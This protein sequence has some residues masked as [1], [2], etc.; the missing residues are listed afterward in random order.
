[1]VN[2]YFNWCF[3][4]KKV[5]KETVLRIQKIL[6]KKIELILL[7]IM[8]MKTTSKITLLVT[9]LVFGATS[10]FAQNNEQIS[11][12]VVF[13]FGV[14][15]VQFI[16]WSPNS[17]YQM[18]LTG[19]NEYSFNL[20]HTGANQ[21]LLFNIRYDIPEYNMNGVY[22]VGRTGLQNISSHPAGIIYGKIYVNNRLLN[23][24]FV[25]GNTINDGLNISLLVEDDNL[26]YP[27]IDDANF[28]VY[29]DD[30]IPPEVASRYAYH[31]NLPAPTYNHVS[32]WMQIITDNNII[33]PS[34]IEVDYF[35]LY[36][37]SGDDLVLLYEDQYE[38]Y[39]PVADGGL[40]LRYPFFPAGFDDHDPMPGSATDGV[41]T[42]YPSDNIRKVWHFWNTEQTFIPNIHDYDSYRIECKIRITG[43]ALAQG[44]IDFIN[45][46][47]NSH[48]ELGTSDWYF[49]NGGEWQ[50]VVFDSHESSTS[51]I[52]NQSDFFYTIFP[53]PI[54][55]SFILNL[56]GNI[57]TDYVTV[58]IFEISGKLLKERVVEPN[59]QHVFCLKKYDAGNYLIKLVQ[60]N[61]T[62][63]EILIKR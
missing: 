48:Y 13:P 45:Q 4:M 20:Q 44:G 60:R 35:K 31:R 24:S 40:Y 56:S 28:S 17:P 51:A 46:S 33:N 2:K 42:F 38:T 47:I 41:L 25:T 8:Y 52:N 22:L 16:D 37:R 23:N 55:E 6:L 62:Y 29:I 39:D 14:S 11:I 19:T 32:G 7:K 5:I 49:E 30:R 36:A 34:K 59:Q 27:F 18:E 54:E 15:N 26:V 50:I 61:Q 57:E 21:Q 3:L 9:L 10:L 12:K 53:N 63:T 1:M 43:H 58:E